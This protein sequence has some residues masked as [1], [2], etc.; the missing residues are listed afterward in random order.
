MPKLI[1][2]ETSSD[3]A[4]VSLLLENGEITTRSSSGM[5]THSQFILPMIEAVLAEASIRLADCD[6]IA[7][8]CGPGSFTGVRTACGVAQG[9]A[10]GADLPLI[11]VVS[12]AAMAKRCF[13]R[14]ESTNVLSIL[15]AR[16][17]EV[18][19]AQYRREKGVWHTITEPRI[20]APQEVVSVGEPT[21]CG[22]GLIAYADDFIHLKALEKY[23]EIP[24]DSEAVMALALVAY[25]NRETITAKEAQPLYLRNKVAYT[26]KERLEMKAG[27]A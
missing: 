17:K 11:P 8:G 7:F 14:H 26:I 13:L 15:D 18:Y 4:S 1:A 16:M 24:P 20:T 6:A 23:S 5:A 19:W 10:F 25:Q 9:L 21:V 27:K 2:F 12:L 3:I 22:N